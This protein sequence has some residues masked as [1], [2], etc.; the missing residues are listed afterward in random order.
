[1]AGKGLWP[2]FRVSCFG[3]PG[4]GAT[5]A[6]GMWSLENTPLGPKQFP[7]PDSRA[8]AAREGWDLNARSGKPSDPEAAKPRI[9]T[10]R[11]GAVAG[12]G[13]RLNEPP[14]RPQCHPKIRQLIPA[15]SEILEIP[16]GSFTDDEPGRAWFRADV[17]LMQGLGL[18]NPRPEHNSM[19]KRL[20][21]VNVP[22]AV[23]RKR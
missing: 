20:R 4:V 2:R 14:V 9:P 5:Q 8:L 22:G 7:L 16:P 3:E 12:P 15:C 11:D 10:G 17:L 13:W 6:C 18:G 19:L 1:M 21:R 23:F